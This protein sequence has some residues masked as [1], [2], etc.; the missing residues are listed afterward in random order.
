[1][2]IRRSTLFAA[3]AIFSC[4]A[5]L[6]GPFVNSAPFFDDTFFFADPK[7]S[8]GNLSLSRLLDTRWVWRGTLALTYWLWGISYSAYRIGNLLIHALTAFSLFLF[9]RDLLEHERRTGPDL[10]AF[11]ASLLF[12]VHP[13]AAFA[14]GYILQRSIV[15]AG[16]FSVWMW[17]A[18]HRGIA[19]ERKSWLFASVFFFYLA[20]YS[21]EFAV[22]ALPVALLVAWNASNGS[23]RKAFRSIVLPL[24]FWILI[25]IIITLRVK[26]YIGTTY[27][28]LLL[29]M[30]ITDQAT[31]G[32]L[33][34][35]Y[36]NQSWLFFKYLLYWLLPNGAWMSIDM[37]EPFPP[38]WHS[39]P[40]VAGL[41]AFFAYGSLAGVALWRGIL[42]RLL[43]FGLIAPWLLFLTMFSAVFFQEPFVLYRSYLWILPGTL[44]VAVLLAK[45]ARR[46]QVLALVVLGTVL[47]GLTWSRLQ[48]FSDP[49]SLWTESIERLGGND[50]L[51]GAYRMYNIRAHEYESRGG[52]RN[53][54]AAIADY[55][56]A[57]KLNPAYPNAHNDRGVARFYMGDYAGALR[58]FSTAL[59][60]KPEYQMA[61]RGRGL[62]LLK[63]GRRNEGLEDLAL[64]CFKFGFG[65][66]LYQYELKNPDKPL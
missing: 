28:T 62:A 16:L 50:G 2:K 39:W 46:T 21:K 11:A 1:M 66:D 14:V 47:F 15:L 45:F 41:A 55:D 7:G 42:P 30:G 53:L 40:W 26:G 10:P 60:L 43:A 13:V 63:L 38:S 33:L 58:D 22:T 29:H 34:R 44:L 23:V 31:G 12:A 36:T 59:D 25:A 54:A 8:L 3:M 9:V 32:Y 6:Y 56:R 61:R 52:P 4:V 57:I 18:V 35:S 37:R 20:V 24:L 19:G 49:V 5:L 48:I 51:P 65:C 17:I 27:E 64:A